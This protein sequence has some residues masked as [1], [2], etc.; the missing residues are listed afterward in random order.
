MHYTRAFLPILVAALL[1]PASLSSGERKACTLHIINSENKKV[2]VTVERANTESLRRKGL[3]FRTGLEENSGM[4]FIFPDEDYRTFWMKNTSI[5][6]SIAYINRRGV[7]TRILDMKPLDTSIV[8]PSNEPVPFA[9][10]VPMG[11]FSRNGIRAGCSV[12]FNGCL[13]K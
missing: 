5:P 12:M 4:L 11:W 6:L 3:M 13:G 7:I 10:E 1:F 8:Y 9:L 2:S